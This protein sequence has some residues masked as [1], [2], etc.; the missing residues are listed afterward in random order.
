MIIFIPYLNILERCRNRISK[1]MNIF[2]SNNFTK[3]RPYPVHPKYDSH[4]FKSSLT[5]SEY[6]S[7]FLHRQTPKSE[8]TSFSN[9]LVKLAYVYLGVILFSIRS[10]VW[11]SLHHLKALLP[12]FSGSSIFS[13]RLIL[14]I[15]GKLLY[16]SS[17]FSFYNAEH[18]RRKN[19]LFSDENY[20]G[21]AHISSGQHC[22]QFKVGT[23]FTYVV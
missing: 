1:K 15:R 18:L 17:K 7:I 5:R 20:N 22:S 10:S 12:I 16:C 9:L 6:S 21:Q 14:K 3:M 2:P 23:H 13:S 19:E 11:F 4:H 8:T